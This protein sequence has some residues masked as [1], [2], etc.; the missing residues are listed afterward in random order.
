MN[1][2]AVVFVAPE[3][4]DLTFVGLNPLAPLEV[5][6]LQM[7]GGGAL[8]RFWGAEILSTTELLIE[9]FSVEHFVI[10]G[11]Q[12]DPEFAGDL[13]DF[14]RKWAPVL[15]GCR[16]HDSVQQMVSR[17]IDA[18]FSFDDA[19]EVLDEFVTRSP[20]SPT[21]S[22]S[23]STV[24][25]HLNLS[26]YAYSDETRSISPRDGSTSLGEEAEWAL[27]GIRS[28]IESLSTL[29]S[30]NDRVTDY[31]LV[32]GYTDRRI[33]DVIDSLGVVQQLEMDF[34]IETYQV[35]HLDKCML[36]FQPGSTTPV[37]P[38]P[39]RSALTVSASYHVAMLSCRLSIPCWLKAENDYYRQKRRG[40]GLPEMSLD[41]FLATPTVT[42]LSAQALGRIE[43]LLRLG[44]AYSYAVARRDNR[45]TKPAYVAPASVSAK[46]PDV[47]ALPIGALK[48]SPLATHEKDWRELLNALEW[49]RSQHANWES[50]ARRLEVDVADLKDWIDQLEAV[51]SHFEEQH[52]VLRRRLDEYEIT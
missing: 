51:K 11:Q 48:P 44:E 24:L 18:G 9:H 22:D 39:R 3:A 35:L 31:M 37:V 1:V 27:D 34:P 50:L 7:Y 8:N 20:A 17:G 52:A 38:L 6:Y 15:V 49:E 30:Q 23:K 45:G 4:V 21:T 40:L 46:E 12:V 42:D 36:S 41:D 47:P 14:V 26:R 16:D 43:W 25:L 2:D 13:A 19:W 29:T 32:Q 5:R 10:S 28:V 33:L